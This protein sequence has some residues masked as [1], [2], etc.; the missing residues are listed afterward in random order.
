VAA[1]RPANIMM[2]KVG[3][4]VRVHY[5]RSQGGQ[6][7]ELGRVTSVF[8][9][10]G[11]FR[12]SYPPPP[13]LA[14][15]ADAGGCV[16]AAAAAVSNSWVEEADHISAC[17]HGVIWRRARHEPPKEAKKQRRAA[18]APVQRSK[19][20]TTTAAAA[21]AAPAQ[22]MTAISKASTHSLAGKVLPKPT[23]P[24][25][26]QRC[27]RDSE[28][29][30]TAQWASAPM[31]PG[32][33][34]ARW[35]HRHRH[36]CRRAGHADACSGIAAT[37]ASAGVVSNYDCVV[38]NGQPLRL[39][40]F[41]KVA[42]P[43]SED[44]FWIAQL[45]ELWEQPPAGGTVAPDDTGGGHGG[46]GGGR[47]RT[48]PRPCATHGYCAVRWVER[49]GGT[50]CQGVAEGTAYATDPKLVFPVIMPSSTTADAD[51]DDDDGHGGYDAQPLEVLLGPCAVLYRGGG[52]VGP[53][54]SPAQLQSCEFYYDMCYDPETFS[55]VAPPEAL[56][57]TGPPL[58]PLPVRAEDEAAA[59][60]LAGVSAASSLP[61]VSPPQRQTLRVLDL[62]AGMGGLGYLDGKSADGAVAIETRWAVDMDAAA[63]ETWRRN[64]PDTATHHMT[65]DDFLFL[66]KEWDSL[67][68][69]CL[70]DGDGAAAVLP[71]DEAAHDSDESIDVEE[72]MQRGHLHC[73]HVCTAA[74]ALNHV[75]AM[76]LFAGHVEVEAVV[77]HRVG[78]GGAAGTARMEFRVRWA[79]SGADEDQWLTADQ[80][81]GCPALLRA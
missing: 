74:V 33:A 50:V 14:A 47:R 48:R 66:L 43:G 17:E 29:K 51:A 32:V 19:S 24:S 55:F 4:A 5:P 15:T 22:N 73:R 16:V 62:F 69:T 34:A 36:R 65:V 75:L 25:K 12:V 79:G 72:G 71:E 18:Q 20:T 78:H 28:R 23:L 3:T 40:D 38:V 52:G 68:R 80:L 26:R 56:A 76:V 49:I 27:A 13:P 61:V 2:P 1:R 59:D 70:G 60:P 64:R 21:G 53:V 7:W 67:C 46:G 41:V 45:Q 6:G 11:T 30:H 58:L 39:G 37:T 44:A 31:S 77:S 54:P 57:P 42:P 10:Q 9:R 63:C 35:P 81:S 8:P